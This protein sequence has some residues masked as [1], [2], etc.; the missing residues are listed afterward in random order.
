MYANSLKYLFQ[1]CINWE[2]K[3]NLNVSLTDRIVL[4]GAIADR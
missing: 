3:G 4:V 1:K 2:Q